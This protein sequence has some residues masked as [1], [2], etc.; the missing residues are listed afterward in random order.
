MILLMSCG[1]SGNSRF[2]TTKPKV[3]PGQH[4]IIKSDCKACHYK[5]RKG[6]GPAFIE[7][8]K[9]YRPDSMYIP[10]LADKIKKG[11]SG[12]WGTHPM[13]PHPNLSKKELET[14]ATYILSLDGILKK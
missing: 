3:P 7:I 13:S 2:N 4:L 12:V 14:I 9:R 8:A 10:Y 11:G 5:T 1:E 6:I